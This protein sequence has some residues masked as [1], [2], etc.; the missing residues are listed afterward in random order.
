MK[1]WW[2][3]IRQ[4]A[5]LKRPKLRTVQYMFSASVLTLAAFLGAAV[6][7]A[8]EASYVRLAVAEPAVEAGERVAVDI[9]AYAHTPVNAIDITIA[10]P[11][12]AFEVT[13]VDRGESV[14]TIWTEDPIIEADQVILR[15]GT[16]KRG[17]VNEHKI[18]TIEFTALETG[19]QTVRAAEVLLLAGDGQGSS[20]QTAESMEKAVGLY[21]F[22]ENTDPDEMQVSA[23]VEVVTDID[24]DGKVSLS[25]ISAFMAAWSSR[26]KIYDFNGDRR[27]TFHDFSIILADFFLR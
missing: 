7:T 6:I 14:L 20:V 2:Y 19:Q 24:G 17:F 13:S 22:D 1:T 15:G 8:G 11:E 26:S 10:Y 25:D 4:A 3:R 23:T 21:V 16:F 5:T 18:A 27:M 12:D 9:Y